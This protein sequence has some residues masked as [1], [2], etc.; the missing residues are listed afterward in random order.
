MSLTMSLDEIESEF[1]G[2]SRSQLRRDAMAI[3]KLAEALA[4][5][6]DAQLTRI[7]LDETLIAEIRRTRNTHQPIAR[8]RQRQYKEKFCLP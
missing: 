4:R 1:D 7:P 8:K 5:L 3:F 6:S 2:P